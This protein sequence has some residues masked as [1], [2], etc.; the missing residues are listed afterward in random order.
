MSEVGCCAPAA[1]RATEPP[2]PAATIARGGDPPETMVD[3][4][5]GTYAMGDDSVWAYPDDGES[6]VHDVHVDPFRIDR[7]ALDQR[8]LRRVRRRN[9]LPHR[10]RNLRLVVRLRRLPPRRL[11]RHAVGRVG[12][13]VATGVRRRLVTSRWAT[14]RHCRPGRSSRGARVVERRAGL[15]HVVGHTP[16]DRSR[17]GVR[18]AWWRRHVVSLGRRPRARRRAPDERVPGPVPG[19]EH[20]GRRL[21][22]HRPGRRVPSQRVRIAQRDRERVG[23]VRGLVRPHLLRVVRDHEPDRPCGR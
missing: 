18:G 3:L 19:R 10:R 14:L 17:M 16:A 11:P 8:T 12:A 22:G 4:P 7:Y 23:V 13:V 6:P 1:E 21:R 15:L 5:G 9:R 2:E 20:R